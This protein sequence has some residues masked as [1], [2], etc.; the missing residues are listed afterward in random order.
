[1]LVNAKARFA[2]SGIDPVSSLNFKFGA[3]LSKIETGIVI[4]KIF[5]RRMTSQFRDHVLTRHLIQ[6][7]DE[8]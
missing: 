4:G 6:D 2:E 1:M 7:K 8:G 3:E 5:C